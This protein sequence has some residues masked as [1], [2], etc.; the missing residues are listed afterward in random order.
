L[1]PGVA[2]WLLRLTPAAGFAIEQSIP[3]Y[4][5]LDRLYSPAG[6]SYPLAPWAGLLVL[7]CWAAAALVLA[8]L[9]QR[10]RDA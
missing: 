5:Q 8:V 10:R 7:C 2:A 4:P 6:G 9:V 1:P 3:N